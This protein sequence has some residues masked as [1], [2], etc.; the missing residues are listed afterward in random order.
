MLI[1]LRQMAA[2][3]PERQNTAVKWKEALLGGS[4]T[5]A[6]CEVSTTPHCKTNIY[7]PK[8]NSFSYR[9]IKTS[10]YFRSNKL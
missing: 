1:T 7:N 4:L 3:T 8:C 6:M 5:S 2:V 10:F 9:M